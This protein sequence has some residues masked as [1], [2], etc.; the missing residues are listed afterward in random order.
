[1]GTSVT[2]KNLDRKKKQIFVYSLL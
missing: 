1:M 2:L